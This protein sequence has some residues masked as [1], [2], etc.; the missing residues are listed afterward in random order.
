[1]NDH[2]V[3]FD[4]EHLRIHRRCQVC[5]CSLTR[6]HSHLYVVQRQVW[7][8]IG[9]TNNLRRRINELSRPAWRKHVLYPVGM[10]WNEPLHQR[11]VVLD[12]GFMEHELHQRFARF[13]AAGEWFV[14]GQDIKDW[15][16]EVTG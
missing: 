8:K 11:A 7:I 14:K 12:G 5:G 2:P 13:H 16:E 3:L 6:L 4:A 15:I 10:D 9:A 1:V